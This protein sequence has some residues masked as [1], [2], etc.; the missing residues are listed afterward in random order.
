MEM[1]PAYLEVAAQALREAGF[2][3][4]STSVG[5][6]EPGSSLEEITRFSLRL[7]SD[8]HLVL[9]TLHYGDQPHRYMLSLEAWGGLSFTPFPLDSWKVWPDRIEFKF[10]VEPRSGL[11]LSFFV[12]TKGLSSPSPS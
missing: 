1:T 10:S 7:G 8:R 11:G 2:E 9:E 6:D 5:V 4:E 12:R 3:C